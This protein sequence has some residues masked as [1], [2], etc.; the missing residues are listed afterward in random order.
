MRVLE[1][2]AA[3]ASLIHSNRPLIIAHRGYSQLAPE[4][5]L[6]A[7]RLAT[8]TGV[9]FVEMDYRHS[10]D[11]I[12]VVIHDPKLD[13]TTNAFKH[14]KRKRVSVVS[15]TAAELQQLD[16]GRWFA[17]G[18]AGAKIPLLS[19]ALEFVCAGG[20]ALVE[21]KAGEP[22][23]CIRL[24]REKGWLN[25]VVIQSFDWHFLRRF[26]EEEPSAMLAALGPA[27]RLPNGKRPLGVVRK[28]N[29][30]WLHQVSK[31][32]AR[33]VVWS[34]KVSKRAV[35]LAHER[36]LKV[37]VYTINEPRLARR[38]LAAGV[39]GIITNDPGML[40][41]VVA[42]FSAHKGRTG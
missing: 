23:I 42:G 20:A 25:Q 8:E 39:D 24:L 34:Q 29:L 33:V 40:R 21:H 9:D 1:T 41:K 35:H 16:A 27:R 32:G 11:G 6:P 17:P 2:K 15:K 19:Q 22:R 38:L 26:H 3:V 36:G 37:W 7:F 14:W 30:A 12:P 18:Y 31:T 5:T 13:R 10:K 4:N 28:L